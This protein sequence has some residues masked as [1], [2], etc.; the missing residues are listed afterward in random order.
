MWDGVFLFVVDMLNARSAWTV[1]VPC[2]RPQTTR[3]VFLSQLC[4]SA[5][6]LAPRKNLFRGRKWNRKN[7]SSYKKYEWWRF[8]KSG[9]FKKNR[10]TVKAGPKVIIKLINNDPRLGRRGHFGCLEHLRLWQGKQSRLAVL[11]LRL[12]SAEVER[13]SLIYAFTC[14]PS[15]ANSD[16]LE[17]AL[18]LRPT[19]FAHY[20]FLQ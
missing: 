8:V 2:P 4:I 7:R 9:P 20:T 16:R 14:V 15:R 12:F 17:M 18:F 5:T 6:F 10:W 3:F 11:S 19:A 13:W 1:S